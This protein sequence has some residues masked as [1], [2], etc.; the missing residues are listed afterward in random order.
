MSRGYV[1]LNRSRS[2]YF[3]VVKGKLHRLCPYLAIALVEYGQ[4]MQAR[5]GGCVDLI[6]H[7]IGTIWKVTE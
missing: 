3:H 5:K 4:R 2:A 6:G 1:V 7:R